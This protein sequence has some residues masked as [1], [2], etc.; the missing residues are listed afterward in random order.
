MSQVV[1][2]YHL[3]EKFRKE[4][5][6][7]T[8]SIPAEQQ[9]ATLD[10]AE[11]SAEDRAAILSEAAIDGGGVARV[12]IAKRTDYSIFP[13]MLDHFLVDSEKVADEC[14]KMTLERDEYERSKIE[15]RIKDAIAAWQRAIANENTWHPNEAIRESDLPLVEKFGMDISKYRELV[16][17]WKR[18]QPIWRAEKEAAEAKATEARAAAEIRT[19]EA[20]ATAEAEKHVWANQFGSEHLKR[21]LAAGHDCG[22]MYLIERALVEYP[23]FILDYEKNSKWQDRSCPSVKALDMRD[24]I[25]KQHPGVTATIVWLTDEPLANNHS[26]DDYYELFEACE[27]IVVDDPIYP[28]Y[29]IITV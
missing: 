8:G 6:L 12:K 11:A 14:R 27:A 15:I 29:L 10:L 28:R 26:Y 22:R 4:Q 2:Q 25:L 13:I 18:Q 7:A 17:E 19:A 5:G 9:T 3:S 24:A 16:A 23:G 20:K 1:V 21:G